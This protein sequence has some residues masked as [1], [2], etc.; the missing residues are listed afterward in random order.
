MTSKE[1]HLPQ[2]EE[3]P[4]AQCTGWDG[5]PLSLERAQIQGEKVRGGSAD[6]GAG[7][8]TPMGIFLL[9][10]AGL[11][12]RQ[13]WADYGFRYRKVPLCLWVCLLS[14]LLQPLCRAPPL[15]PGTSGHSVWSQLS[16]IP[17]L[18]RTDVLKPGVRLAGKSFTQRKD[19]FCLHWRYQQSFGFLFLIATAWRKEAKGADR[20]QGN[21]HRV[22][23]PSTR[24]VR[25]PPFRLCCPSAP[26]SPHLPWHG[27]N[28]P[29]CAKENLQSPAAAGTY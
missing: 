1:S 14:I 27:C 11:A 8:P 23:N 26:C 20:N 18:L 28:T 21:T 16:C 9:G 22:P 29:Y 25:S 3:R 24:K 6:Q 15:L 12:S 17:S 5:S 10:P 4:R 7:H 19:E 13:A 2:R